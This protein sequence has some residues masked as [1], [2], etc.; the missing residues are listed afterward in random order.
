M[1]FRFTRAHPARRLRPGRGAVRDDA[2]TRP[3]T[4]APRT[5]PTGPTAS[6][7]PPT[8]SGGRRLP[9]ESARLSLY[10]VHRKKQKREAPGGG[11]F[12]VSAGWLRVDSDAV[13][14][15][16]MSRCRSLCS[17]RRSA[18]GRVLL[19]ERAGAQPHASGRRRR[20]RR[21]RA[22]LRRRARRR[23]RHGVRL[24]RHRLRPG[25]SLLR[26]SDARRSSEDWTTADLSDDWIFA[27]TGGGAWSPPRPS[28]AGTTF[29][30]GFLPDD[31][32]RALVSKDC[33][34]LGAWWLAERD[35]CERAMRRGCDA[36]HGMRHATPASCSR[37]PT[38]R[39]PGASFK[40]SSR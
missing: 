37:W 14:S 21:H 6:T 32:P 1:G 29:V 2:A 24:R 36:E 15:G 12:A 16:A 11:G 38:T 19:A 10:G 18:H 22:L 17:P 25:A 20:W 27:P 4:S 9:S 26:A 35:A 39:R 5:S 28:I 8:C 7:S 3:T 33:V 30:G 34:S 40:T 31:S 23:Q 13:W